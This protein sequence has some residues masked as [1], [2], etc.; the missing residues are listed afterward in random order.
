M[1]GLK[2]GHWLL[3]LSLVLLLTIPLLSC[4]PSSNM[5]HLTEEQVISIIQVYGLPTIKVYGEPLHP[6]GHWAAVYESGDKWR[7]RGAGVVKLEGEDYYCP[8][9]WTYNSKRIELV[10]IEGVPDSLPSLPEEPK[11]TQE[12]REDLY[13]E[14]RRLRGLD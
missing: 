3:T 11:L 14:L 2:K 10:N 8:T 9:E 7:V 5:G 4:S 13:E 12:E 1:K 6:V